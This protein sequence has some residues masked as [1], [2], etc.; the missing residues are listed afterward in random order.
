MIV[1]AGPSC[2]GKST[3]GRIA[4]ES[5]FEVLETTTVVKEQFR[6]LS[7]HGEDIIGFCVRLFHSA[8]E[9][10]F[11]RQ[12]CARIIDHGGDTR[13]LVCIGPRAAGEIRCFRET[14][15]QVKVIGVFADAS[16]RYQ[17]GILRDRD[18][19]AR[20]L[21][22]FIDRDMREYS[23]G[24]AALFSSSLDLLLLNNGSIKDFELAVRKEL[25]Q[26]V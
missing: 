3:F 2:S 26:D 14:F 25:K 10:V 17:R 23:M 9:D 13:R 22:A 11:A 8:G 21:E 1:V 7:R 4:R 18:D 6:A 12:N 16:L 5:E 20:T 19:C 15:E 24:L